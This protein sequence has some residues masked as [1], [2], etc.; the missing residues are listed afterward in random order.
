MNN[1][2][3]SNTQIGDK[4][5]SLVWGHGEVSRIICLKNNSTP[6][7]IEVL[8]EDGGIAAYSFEGKFYD[9]DF[10]P[11]LFKGHIDPE[12]FQVSYKIK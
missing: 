9:D 5:T 3:F 2:D 12:S 7:P 4:V 11:S 6:F 8:F 10:L 1:S